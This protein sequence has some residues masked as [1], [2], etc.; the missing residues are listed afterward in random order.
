MNRKRVSTLLAA[1]LAFVPLAGCWHTDQ[2]A[3]PEATVE[4]VAHRLADGHPV[5]IWQALPASY[6]SDVSGL[7]HEFS[8]KVDRTVWNTTFVVVTKLTRL[9]REKQH[10][11][12]AHP[13]V[14]QQI[15]TSG[16]TNIEGDW[17]GI[18]K[19]VELLATSE[20]ANLDVLAE[21]D[22]ETFLRGTGWQVMNQVAALSDPATE[23]RSNVDDKGGTSAA[24]N[25]ETHSDKTS[26]VSAT[27]YSDYLA[28]AESLRTVEATLISEQDDRAT[29]RIE[30]EGWDARIE[31]LVRVEGKW[32]PA[33]LAEG[34]PRQLAELRVSIAK[35]SNNEAKQ[36]VRATL[37]KLS[38]AEGVLDS[39]L[40]TET[41]EQFNAAVGAA[42]GA[43]IRIAMQAAMNQI[44]ETAHKGSA[45]DSSVSI[46]LSTP[47]DPMDP[48]ETS[49]LSPDVIGP[50]LANLPAAL[51]ATS[52]ESANPIELNS[53]PDSLSQPLIRRTETFDTPAIPLSEANR[54]VGQRLRVIAA[55]G[56]DVVAV[57]SRADGDTLTFERPLSTGVMSFEMRRHEIES[58]HVPR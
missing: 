2:A 9:L 22:I 52:I 6:Q 40:A 1:A 11:I 17:N 43:M 20:L 32:I 41:T 8:G 36:D 34:W 48:I 50:G 21:L 24:T 3:G 58:L 14:A 18:I 28:A 51:A 45:T 57:L 5:A 53:P 13:L 10:L 25:A 44:S 19:L 29:V 27:S 47:T 23:D 55:D 56:M 54:H 26:I 39:L 49:A 31:E 42:M 35:M 7:L 37:L 15:A 30:A 33:S 38:M 46:Q 12:L 4:H 16:S